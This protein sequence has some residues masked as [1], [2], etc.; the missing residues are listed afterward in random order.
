MFIVGNVD[1]HAV[2]NDKFALF[3]DNLTFRG[4][5]PRACNYSAVSLKDWGC[6]FS[7]SNVNDK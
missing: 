5:C 1:V 3:F 4:H 7:A 2:H 6:R